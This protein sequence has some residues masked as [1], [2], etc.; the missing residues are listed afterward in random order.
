MSTPALGPTQF[1]IQWVTRSLSLEVK[2][3]VREADHSLP[4]S[5]EV[6]NAWSCTSTPQYAFI[7]WCLV[8]HRDN[9]TFTF[10]LYHRKDPERYESRSVMLTIRFHVVFSVQVKY[11]C[12]ALPPCSLHVLTSRCQAQWYLM[13]RRNIGHVAV[14]NPGLCTVKQV[15]ISWV[16]EFGCVD[17]R[18]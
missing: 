2:R 11:T 16:A 5:A 18:H 14:M 15:H 7:A 10:Y 4:S 9:F 6:K 17:L 12:G 1:P 3:P 13:Y 8:K